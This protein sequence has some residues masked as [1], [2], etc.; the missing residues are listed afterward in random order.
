MISK[1]GIYYS[2]DALLAGIFLITALFLMITSPIHESRFQQRNYLSQDLLNSLSELTISEIDSIKIQELIANGTLDGQKSV[3]EQAGEYWALENVASATELINLS[4]D[5]NLLP[6]KFINITMGDSYTN[7]EIFYSGEN[8]SEKFDSGVSKRMIAGISKGF[9]V[10]GYSSSAYLKKIRNKKTSSYAYFGG[11]VGQGNISF[12][13]DDIPHDFIPE[14]T[15]AILLEGD[16]GTNFTFY[17]NG[18]ACNRTPTANLF[19]VIKGADNVSFWDVTACNESLVSGKNDFSINFSGILNASYIAGGM[20][21]IAYRTDE[22]QTESNENSK[23]YY[24]P[25]ISGVANLYDSFYIPGELLTMDVALHFKS[26]EETYITI[27]ERIIPIEATGSDQWVHLSNS[28]LR[29][30]LNFD[31]DLLSINTVPVRFAAYNATVTTIT[32]GDA[33][34]VLITDMSGSMKKSVMDWDQGHTN[35]KC[36]TV[37]ADPD[38]RRTDVAICVDGEFVDNI[39]NFTGNRVWPVI[40][41]ND[42]IKYYNNPQDADAIK[43][44]ISSYSQGKGKTCIS[45]AINEAYNIL[46]TYSNSSRKKF[47]VLMTDGVPTHCAQGSC[48]STSTVFGTKYCEGL[49]DEEGQNCPSISDTCTTCTANSGPVDNTFFSANR[50]FSNIN[51]TIYTIGFGPMDDCPLCEH[52]LNETAQIGNGTYQHSNNVTEVRE[53]YKNVSIEILNKVTLTSQTVSIAD[54][55]ANSTLYGDSHINFSFNPIAHPSLPGK[56]SIIFEEELET[57]TDSIM[58]PT[59]VELTDAAVLS[60]SGIHWADLVITNNIV[61]FNLSNYYVPYYRLGDPFIIQVPVNQTRAGLNT[62]FVSTGDGPENRTG[63]S[64]HNKFI[65]R[66]LVSSVTSRTDVK[67]KMIGCNWNV[68]FEDGENSI[69]RVPETYTGSI[70]CSYRPQNHSASTGAYDPEDTYA[71][72]VFTLFNQLDTDND[73]EVLLNINNLDLEI[74]TTTIEGIPYLWGPSVATVEVRG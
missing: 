69:I 23:S 24:F 74:S 1:K 61:S 29:D 12:F 5:V 72:A 9:P 10:S 58:I 40:I 52:V 67:E 11:L 7:Y 17:I 37:F 57:C 22:L 30:D 35:G 64:P 43:G 36:S 42:E 38:T 45:C 13:I 65:Y 54:S 41:H 59:D 25:G 15:V 4:F 60:Y 26:S 31:Y 14:K 66:G 16:F 70:N 51:A 34:V 33:D 39:L 56:I 32:S 71:L 53:I 21:K 6:N 47:I 49:C 27:G 50:A 28:Y 63:C 8:L 48:T 46:E 44:Y 18:I 19:Q 73:G 20:L 68:S 55:L 3:I 62:F 2:M